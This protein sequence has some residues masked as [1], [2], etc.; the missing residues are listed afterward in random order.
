MYTHK[1]RC[2]MGQLKAGT[3]VKLLEEV[4]DVRK[5]VRVHDEYGLAKSKKCSIL[6]HIDDLEPLGALQERPGS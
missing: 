1:L 4:T 5:I 2:D 6:I 3:R